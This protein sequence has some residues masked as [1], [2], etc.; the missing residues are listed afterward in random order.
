MK[1][2]SMIKL[3]LCG[4]PHSGK[5][6]FKDGLI[7]ILKRMASSPY[8]Y[9]LNACPDGEG[10][11][12]HETARVDPTLAAQERQK[13]AFSEAEV[14]KFEAWVR[15]VQEP[16]VIVDVGGR[17]SPEN[18]RIMS[19]TTHAV[20][21][22]RDGTEFAAWEAFCAELDIVVVAKIYSDYDAQADVIDWQAGVL[23]GTVHHLDRQVSAVERPIIQELANY[24]VKL[25][26]DDGTPTDGMLTDRIIG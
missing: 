4:P 14:F 25:V 12:F 8:P 17:I 16:M 7:G 21:L 23:T 15:D 19:H 1:P 26:N 9:S 13:G 18:R 22:S 20:I 5:S 3:V 24:V 11:W 2:Q 10:S 6:C